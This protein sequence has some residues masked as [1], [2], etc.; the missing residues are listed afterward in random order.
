LN[1][2]YK[3]EDGCVTVS[4]EP[5]WGVIINPKWLETAQYRVSGIA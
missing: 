4:Q 1:D 2:P 3:V 5:G